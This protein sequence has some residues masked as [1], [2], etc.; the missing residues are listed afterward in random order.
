M[1]SSVPT[2]TKITLP[3]HLAN[4]GKHVYGDVAALELQQNY[5]FTDLNYSVKKG[6]TFKTEL[7]MTISCMYEKPTLKM[8][9]ELS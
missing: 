4:V 5:I 9:V 1:I 8:K 3:L 7:K 6:M 2:D